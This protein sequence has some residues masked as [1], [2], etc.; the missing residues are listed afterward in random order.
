MR[1]RSR[2]ALVFATRPGGT[3]IDRDAFGGNPFATALIQL[4]DEDSIPLRR[5]PGRLRA[6]TVRGSQG[7]QRPQWTRWPERLRWSF[8]HAPGSR[9]ERRCA[10]VLI[11]SNYEGAGLAPLAGAA[12]DERR[13]SAMFAAN[14]FS[15]VQ[16]VAPSRAALLDALSQFGRVARR[17]DTAVIYSTGHGVESNGSVYLLPGNYPVKDGCS[18]ARLRAHA[19]SVDR[20]AAACRGSALNLVFFAGCRTPASRMTNHGD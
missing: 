8:R 20:I 5:F 19:V 18:P 17:H 15:V 1:K 14:G 12:H 7:H 3:T 11:V 4:S 9:Q 13:L 2:P 10:L 16:G 6:L